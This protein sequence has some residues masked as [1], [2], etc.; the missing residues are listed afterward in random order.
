ME[1]AM[2]KRQ[3]DG[4]ARMLCLGALVVLCFVSQVT[5]AQ[6]A[7][8]PN[9]SYPGVFSFGDSL[10][11]VGNSIAAFPEQFAHAELDPNGHIFPQHAAD[12]FTDGKLLVDFLAFGVRRRP[13][14][15]VL[16]GTAGDFTYGTCFAAYG[17]PART[18]KVWIKDNGF[19]TPF[20][21]DVQYQWYERYK[22]RVW[23][24]ESPVFNPPGRLN[25]S[26]PKLATFNESLFTVWAGYHDYFFSLYDKIL[27]VAETPKIVP[28]VVQAIEDHLVK[29]MTPVVYTPPATPSM[30]M[31]TAKTILVVNLPPLGCIPA[32]LTLFGTPTAKYDNYG[33]LSALN[34]ISIAHNTLLETKIIAL[35]AKFPAAKILYGDAYSVYTDILKDPKS[36]NATAPLQA[37][38][39]VGGAYNFNTNV[40]CGHAGIVAN[41]FVN[42]TMS[43]PAMP[44]ADPTAHLSWDGIHTSNTFNKAAAT[45]FLTGKHITPAGGLNCSPDFT[46]WE[47]RS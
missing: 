47:A 30:I 46:F 36:Y 11:D 32:M 22:I 19:N 23:F 39:G 10:S 13:I 33:C 21:L 20:S 28:D 18:V 1:F 12:R 5:K 37:C 14:Y 24:Y 38:C 6:A 2:G 4:A 9:C 3:G 29:I 25:Q 34:L 44:C 27:T 45:A 31:P 16:R 26:L 35:R 17:G 15:P 8:L 41:K 40:T 43:L 42:L 7:T